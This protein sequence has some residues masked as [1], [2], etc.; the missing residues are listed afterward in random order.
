LIAGVFYGQPL[1]WQLCTNLNDLKISCVINGYIEKVA[2][3]I[4]M[5]SSSNAEEAKV[6]FAIF[7][8]VLF[9][10]NS[11]CLAKITHLGSS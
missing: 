7:T 1:T 8:F 11:M 6:Y 2:S 9:D 4:K 3:S 10:D 5:Q